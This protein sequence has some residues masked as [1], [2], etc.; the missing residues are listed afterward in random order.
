MAIS[1]YRISFFLPISFIF[2]CIS[3][4]FILC[5][6]TKSCLLN[7]HLFRFFFLLFFIVC[8]RNPFL[9]ICTLFTCSRNPFLPICTLFTV[10][11]LKFF[12]ICF[13]YQL[14]FLLSFSAFAVFRSF[15][16]FSLPSL[17]YCLTFCFVLP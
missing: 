1:F 10:S 11:V 16:H 6:H 8:S 12:F 14:S 7:P 5:P 4:I 13:H 3:F 2:L 15:H 17:S 9:P